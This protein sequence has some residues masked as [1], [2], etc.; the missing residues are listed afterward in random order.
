MA[1]SYTFTDTRIHL[2]DVNIVP[3]L[4]L[5]PAG[6]INNPDYL[7]LADESAYNKF[8]GAD[9]YLL[10][11][12]FV[13]NRFPPR[14][15]EVSRLWQSYRKDLS[16]KPASLWAVQIPIYLRPRKA[17][18]SVKDLPN[19]PP[20]KA[21]VYAY[22]TLSALGWSTHI[23]VRLLQALKPTQ[24]ADVCDS[25]RGSSGGGSPYLL[26]GES[27]SASEVFKH[28]RKLVRGDILSKDTQVK[29][30]YSR[31]IFIDI[32]GA[33]GALARYPKFPL[34]LLQALART[35]DGKIH[36]AQTSIHDGEQVFLFP[37]LRV[38]FIDPGSYNFSISDF[39]QGVFTFLQKEAL[40][41]EAKPGG[42][43]CYA[44]N[45]REMRWLAYTW[46]AFA[47]LMQ[48]ESE[49]NSVIA[50]LLE[51]GA[52][53]LGNVGKIYNGRTS[54]DFFS[55]YQPLLDFTEGMD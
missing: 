2:K 39:N 46:I 4:L 36:P 20:E 52:A 21:R 33:E 41:A 34:L 13:G 43:N 12:N 37:D 3:G 16:G 9:R 5:D 44:N 22:V 18:L 49:K 48:D 8:Q 30:A 27:M 54:L 32:M 51:N 38:T 28:F 35:I 24:L 31:L 19:V 53:A 6:T 1:V 11:P 25:L 42:V 15:R 14:H 23:E 17:K 7:F 50:G 26:D 29:T 10:S 55:Y 40:D 47:R 45:T